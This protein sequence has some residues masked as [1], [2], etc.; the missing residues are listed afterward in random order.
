MN[1]TQLITSKGY[2]CQEHSVQTADG[3]ILGVQR[4]P[5]GK[6]NTGISS[7]PVVLLQHGLLSCSSCW[8]ENLVDQSLGFILADAG[9]DVWLGNNRGNTYSRRH[10]KYKPT[11]EEFWAFSEAMSLLFLQSIPPLYHV[12]QMRTPVAL[13][14]GTNDFLADPI[15]VE[16]LMGKLT[17]SIV[18]H[19]DIDGWE[20]LD[21]IWAMDA[22]KE[23]YK[24]IVDQ[25]RKYENI[26]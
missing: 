19:K 2:P 4:I 22:A 20:H 23:C 7:R 1:V 10:I 18:Y 21:F 3:F 24:E 17:N 5:Y 8:V 6:T 25:I 12:D 15:D 13:F 9:M 14:T 11:D 16:N 26:G